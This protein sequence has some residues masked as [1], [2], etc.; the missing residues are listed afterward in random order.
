M[1]KGDD[2]PQTMDDPSSDAS[3]SIV[4]RPSSAFIWLTLATLA[5]LLIGLIN[6]REAYLR[7][8]TTQFP[9]PIAH[10]GVQF[11]VN[12]PLIDSFDQIAAANI[13]TIKHTF[14]FS[15]DF[16]WTSASR[17]FGTAKKNNLTLVPLL[18]GDP[19]T[20]FAPPDIDAYTAWAAEFATRF[21]D[22]VD[23]Y[24]IWDEPNLTSHWGNQKVNPDEYAALLTTTYH[25]IKAVDP[26]ASIAAAPLA[27]TTERGD[28]TLNLADPL[29]LQ[30]LYEAEAQF[31]IVMG[32]PYGFDHSPDNRTVNIDT[33]NFSRIILLR[34][35]MEHNNDAGKPIW[36]GNW[37][38]NH[39]PDDWQGDPSIWGETTLQEQTTYTQ[40]AYERV[41]KEWPWMGMMF[42]E[43][44]EPDDTTDPFWGF[45]LANNRDLM[46]WVEII[47]DQF[48]TNGTGFHL[49]QADTAGTEW[50]GDWRFSPE[51]GADSSEKYVENGDVRDTLSY[52]WYGTDLGIRVR[53]A[54]F[55]ARY[56]VT[57]DGQPANARPSDEFGTAVV[58]DAPNPNEDYIAIE[59]IATG[60]EEGWHTLELTAH[61]GWGQW[62]LNGF[63]VSSQPPASLFS[64]LKPLLWVLAPLLAVFG[65]RDLRRQEKWWQAQSQ[66]FENITHH[67]QM[68]ILGG[69]GTILSASG[70]L[71]FSTQADTLFR[72]LPESSQLAAVLGTAA[73]FY[74]TPYFFIW[75]IALIV[76]FII[77][78]WRPTYGL[79]LIALSIPFY[80]RPEL[81][82]S[83]AGQ[84]L[85]SPTEI[86]SWLT[87]L[88]VIIHTGAAVPLRNGRSITK[89]KPIDWAVLSLVAVATASL[90]YTNRLDVATNEWRVV[91]VDSALFYLLLRVLRPSQKEIFTIINAFILS[92]IL[93]SLYGIGQ[94]AFGFAD[95]I[96]SEGGVM[97]LQSI[98]GSPNNVALYLG[99]ILPFPLALTL[100]GKTNR[101][102]YGI[103]SALLLLTM[104]L[105]VSK[106]G[107]I[108]GLPVS[109]F[110]IFAFWLRAR[111]YRI[112]PWLIAFIIA[113]I[114]GFIALL[115]IPFLAQRLDVL[116]QT[117]FVRLRLWQASIEM[118]REN[119]LLGIGL[120]NF[121]YEHRGRY[122]LES[123]WREPYLNHPHNF[124]FDFAT[125]LG[126]LGLAVGLWLWT[127][128]GR[129][130]WSAV[131][132][133]E[134]SVFKPLAI[135]LLAAFGHATAHGLVDH[136]FFLIDLAYSFM[137]MVGLG[138]WMY[139]SEQKSPTVA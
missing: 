13:T 43:Y 118:V 94:I 52:R 130:S 17:A 74:I 78:T 131:T 37:G 53:R 83:V 11:G 90:F 44:H 115:Q 132:V 91:I 129:I 120:D 126:L 21:D 103:I 107:L 7:R 85:F 33:L 105:T 82:K 1:G 31:D 121:L 65:V 110:I 111:G 137:L 28:A 40:D 9:D 54:D 22:E 125:R 23:T 87:L 122:I 36:A 12:A 77:L 42:F 32:K 51:F 133:T 63:S 80:T 73:I 3:P 112:I 113:W 134:Q 84:Y 56:Y 6:F 76:L 24:I 102:V 93:I 127:S 55:R 45:N 109:L 60:L 29:Y 2:R 46:D 75:V 95:L 27:P 35:V 106:G 61:R 104:V 16:D 38:W 79:V 101:L 100:F 136:S 124:F 116:G 41:W 18:D 5:L 138:L 50:R 88:A 117:S 20:N 66:R 4:H 89:L 92:G 123:A 57:V 86:F 14:Y 68:A 70:W 15:D 81:L 34:E 25:A 128:L 62:A 71:T 48:P 135:G 114:G 69:L 99:R 108:F 67:T 72:K 47:P 139:Q 96:T 10:S 58:L 26:S 39:L 30:A 119:P 97:R 19:S 98:Y 8:G 64:R 49:A 59:P